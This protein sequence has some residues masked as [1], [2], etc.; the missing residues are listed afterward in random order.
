MKEPER[1]LGEP[2]K[3]RMKLE[4][5]TMR[6]LLKKR[7]VACAMLFTAVFALAALTGCYSAPVAATDAWTLTMVSVPSDTPTIGQQSSGMVANASGAS[8]PAWRAPAS[9]A[10]VE[11][12]EE[13]VVPCH[14]LAIAVE[15][16]ASRITEKMSSEGKKSV[17]IVDFV[18]ESDEP[19]YF[20]GYLSSE[21]TN[22]LFV[23]GH[24]DVV[25]R[26]YMER[27]MK[28]QNMTACSIGDE[29]SIRKLG[30]LLGVDS[31]LV[32]T[33]SDS[34]MDVRATGTLVSVETGRSYA[35]ACERI[36]KDYQVLAL[37]ND[38]P[39]TEDAASS[40]PALA[41]VPSTTGTNPFAQ[42]QP[43]EG[44]NEKVAQ[45]K[46]CW[47]Q[48][49]MRDAARIARSALVD[50]DFE[51]H[52]CASDWGWVSFALTESMWESF[53]KSNAVNGALYSESM[54]LAEKAVGM[55]GNDPMALCAFGQVL[56]RQGRLSEARPQLEKALTLDP[57]CDRIPPS[58]R[59][60]YLGL[61]RPVNIGEGT[62][63][64]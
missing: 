11:E 7:L 42:N 12:V 64:D 58:F 63:A 14:E 55:D 28:E 33:F 51:K 56:F 10:V 4:I 61:T 24:C 22:R 8:E 57:D 60:T 2:D 62:P 43:G 50:P 16:L 54:K 35:A 44:V 53:G 19:G 59:R 37:M 3:H 47:K 23:A 9:S 52:A 17:A 27:V 5:N 15:N 29:E 26:G 31:V 20:G 30:S 49:K 21:L 46:A 40:Q 32:G 38:E 34:G 41:A 39:A 6:V 1:K 36:Q 48:Y 25:E 45:I 18:P 13:D